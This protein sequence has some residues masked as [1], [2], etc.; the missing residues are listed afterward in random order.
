LVGTWVADEVRLAVEKGYRVI[1]VHEVYEYEITQY[2]PTT[3]EGGIFAQYIDTFLKLK[4]EASGFPDWVRCPEDEDR[5]ICNFHTSEGLELNKTAIHP[6][7]AK[8]A[9]AKLC[10]NSLW[11]KLTERN[12]RTKSKMITD[13]CELYRFLVTP[14]VE[15]VNLMFASDEVVWVSWRYTSEEK[16]PALKHTNEVIGAYVTTGARIHIYRF[17]DR[18]QERALYCDTDSLLF[19]Q[20]VRGPRLIECGDNLGDMTNEL[21]PG[22]YIDEFVSGGPKNYAYKICNRDLSK[23]P[24]TVCKVRG[25]T[26]NYSA[27]HLVNFTVIRDMVLKG[28]PDVV[29][30]KTE[31]KIKRKRKGMTEGGSAC[32]SLI[33]EPEDKIYRLSFLK[34]RRQNDN[35]SVPFG[36]I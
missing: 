1:E 24:K 23:N 9:L 26:L 8:R 2:D 35:T 32:V 12:N 20:D 17:L 16:V 31:K 13:P 18:L 34:R 3:G 36:Y 14:G 29:N 21:K 6:N 27:S 22:E 5:Y 11:G 10:L 30:V 25:I 4:A 28:V 7:P 33:T 15:V 19:I